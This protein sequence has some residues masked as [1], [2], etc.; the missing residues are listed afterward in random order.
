MLERVEN[1]FSFFFSENCIP[2][3][4]GDAELWGME[5]SRS[6]TSPG[7]EAPGPWLGSELA[8]AHCQ[9]GMGALGMAELLETRTG[10]SQGHTRAEGLG[11]AP[12][13]SPPGHLSHPTFLRTLGKQSGGC[14]LLSFTA[15]HIQ[16]RAVPVH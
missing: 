8:N 16:H 9:Q 14:V 3:S 2:F 6:S 13:H 1:N 5:R 15:A 4:A 7:F 10:P 12:Q 11:K